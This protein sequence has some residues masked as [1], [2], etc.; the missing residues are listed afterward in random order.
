M[1]WQ[2]VAGSAITS[3]FRGRIRTVLTVVAV[4][5]GAFT[6]TLTSGM[7]TGVNDY[8]DE[9]VA[10]FG[11]TDTLYVQ[12]SQPLL[13]LSTGTGPRAYDPDDTQV[14]TG[15]GVSFAG[16]SEEN[17]AAV[18]DT[19]GVTEVHPVYNVVPTYL[20]AAGEKF[21][22]ALGVPVHGDGLQM[23]TGSTA[24]EGADEIAIPDSW[25]TDLGFASAQDAVGGA[26][27]VVMTDQVGVER[28]FP[29]RVSGVTQASL[30]GVAMNPLPSTSFNERLYDYQTSGGPQ[31]IP[32]SFVMARAIM[33]DPTHA[34]QV[35]ERL[36]E[37]GMVASTVEDQL[38]MFRTVIDAV[39]WILNTCA[40][41]ALLAASLG[42]VNTLLMSVQERTREI[43]LLKAMGMSKLKVFG[44]F[45]LEAVFIGLLGAAL[46]VTTGV[47]AGS[48]LTQVLAEGFLAGLP[49]LS[50]FAF[51]APTI[52]AIAVAVLT[53]AFLAGTLPAIRA[54]GKD[55]IAA[56]RHE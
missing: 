7:G 48:W 8:I 19:P 15:F 3:I 21:Q 47:A 52:A 46:G 34:P 18:E 35:Q 43:G 45:S 20:E 1:K 32:A 17:I 33:D 13:E 41:I 50:L 39:I 9:T 55:P 24:A 22:L 5:I 54:A 29:A 36:E 11:D 53:I 44:L 6:L 4:F 51:H 40:V 37:A 2:D 12:K 14:A 42:I 30:A 28:S 38:G 49:G 16:L 26:L 25:V 27:E 31:E 56:L 10:A 23:V